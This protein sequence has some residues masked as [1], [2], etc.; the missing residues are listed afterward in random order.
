M[1]SKPPSSSSTANHKVIF[2]TDS[3]PPVRMASSPPVKTAPKAKSGVKPS[4][5]SKK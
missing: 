1:K 4:A 5:I 3:Q 2:A